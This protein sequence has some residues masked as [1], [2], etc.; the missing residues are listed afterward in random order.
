MIRLERLN[1]TA[2]TGIMRKSTE[3]YDGNL[4]RRLDAWHRS[5]L[6]IFIPRLNKRHHGVNVKL[7]WLV[8]IHFTLLE[9]E[10]KCEIMSK[11]V[12]SI[13]TIYPV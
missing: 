9:S 2:D 12:V 10:K 7:V 13:C 11:L 3:F 4:Q 1:M 6:N 5:S 8:T